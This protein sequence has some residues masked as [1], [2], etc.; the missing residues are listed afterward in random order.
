[1]IELKSC[2]FCGGKAK[3]EQTAYGTTEHNSCK[4]SFEIRCRQC[5]ATAPKADGYIV[6]NLSTY[7]ELNIWHDDR[8]KAVAAWNRRADDN[9]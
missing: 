3:I 4:L 5:G 8:G 9:G 6:V 2:P 1:M 7:G